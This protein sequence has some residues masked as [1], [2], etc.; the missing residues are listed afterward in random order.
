MGCAHHNF[1]WFLSE[2]LTKHAFQSERGYSTTFDIGLFP[3]NWTDH[4][5]YFWT[6]VCFWN[7]SLLPMVFLGEVQNTFTRWLCSQEQY[8]IMLSLLHMG[9]CDNLTTI[10][11]LITNHDTKCSYDAQCLS[12]RHTPLFLN[13]FVGCATIIFFWSLSGPQNIHIMKSISFPSTGT[14]Y[15]L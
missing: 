5:N 12:L 2:P 10:F 3:S 8:S 9:R 4:N 14:E 6:A 7:T 11:N 15:S 1:F 13:W